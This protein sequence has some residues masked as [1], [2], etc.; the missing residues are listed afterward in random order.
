LLCKSF[1]KSKEDYEPAKK[2]HA[3]AKKKH[4]EAN[5]DHNEAKKKHAEAEK[6]LLEAEKERIPNGS[7]DQNDKT[8][9]LEFE[10]KLISSAEG[11]VADKAKLIS[12]AADKVFVPHRE[13][14]SLLGALRA[15]GKDASLL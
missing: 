5:E 4:A 1:V 15:A 10:A 3:E 7:S 13:V 8:T 2:K 11:T 14:K 6:N 12:S 9:I